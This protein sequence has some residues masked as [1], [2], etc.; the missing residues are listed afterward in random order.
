[1]TSTSARALQFQ[2][3]AWQRVLSLI[4]AALP[5]AAGLGVDSSGA[6]AQS[7]W[8]PFEEAAPPGS[9]PRR[10]PRPSG[11]APGSSV[12]SP[13]LP[14]D[15]PAGAM[16]PR[17]AV[18]RS[19][20]PPL[21]ASDE[22]VPPA[23]TTTSI[24]GSSATSAEL[25]AALRGLELP[26]HSP[27]LSRLVVRL[28]GPGAAG[29]DNSLEAI[30]ARATALYRAGRTGEAAA[31]IGGIDPAQVEA[32]P[33][34]AALLAFQARLALA[35]GERDRACAA[36]LAVVQAS[37]GVP[38]SVLGEALSI[39]GY[40]G[41]AAGNS[42]AAGLA[43]ALGR[44]QG[45]MSEAARAALDAVAAGEPVALNGL[46]RIGVLDW[47]LAEAAGKL[48]G[49]PPAPDRFEPAA[50]VAVAGS[51]VAPARWRI[52]AAEAAAITNALDVAM[53]GDVY[54]QQ[55]FSATDLAA[56][57]S[58]RVEPWARRALLFKAADGERTPLKRA[59]TVRA[60]LDD[61]RRAGLY[62]PMAAAL[63]PLVG[64]IRP[65]AEVGWFAE[66]AVEVMLAAGRHDE[67]RRWAQLGMEPSVTADRPASSLG[68]W[69][70]LIDIADP[71]IRGDRAQG[72]STLEELALRGRFTP[73][74]L[75]RLA[76]V[77]DALD[78]HVPMR[79]W[80]AASRAPQPTTGRLPPTGVLSDLQEAARRKDPIRTLVLVMQTLGRDGPAGAH[81]I[82][83]G[84]AV[85]ALRRAGFEA[86]AREVGM[87]ALFGLWPRSSSS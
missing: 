1:M 85:R 34:K 80:E 54:R 58:A 55:S 65:V 62:N 53:L 24:P 77:L 52:A 27:A 59:R 36:A 84:D 20:L 3:R 14:S 29:A 35:V 46:H 44:E 9:S 73:D 57:F 13:D 37:A 22:P 78:F 2:P 41:A 18:E 49:N 15:G 50:L 8:N 16:A 66:T 39:N 51:R 42:A 5:F 74:G 47:R 19:D 33:A 43:A 21:P 38:P 83:L 79:L 10:P 30:G 17:D 63:A 72:F 25:A 48:D 82:A 23:A 75:H 7:S 64:E 6:H 86:E 56:P 45:A 32:A 70:A 67:A 31:L 4:V 76:T 87:E 61:A 40:C 11:P 69:L 12:P 71:R 28:L 68:H 26:V 81:M 60:A